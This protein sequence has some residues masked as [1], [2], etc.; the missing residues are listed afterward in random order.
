MSKILCLH[1]TDLDGACA[2]AICGYWCEKMGYDIDY[3]LYNYGYP[4]KESDFDGYDEI[5][6]VD[7][8]FHESSPWVYTYLGPRLTWIDHHKSA[9]E[10]E[11]KNY[12]IFKDLGIAGIREIG[13]GACELTWEYL[14]PDSRTPKLVQYLSTYDTWRKDREGFDWRTCECIQWGCRQEYGISAKDICNYLKLAELGLTDYLEELRS[15]GES[16][17]SYVEKNFTGKLKNYGSFI[18]EFNVEGI[19]SYR[20]MAL[21]T[22]EFTSKVFEGL[23]DPRYYDIM[24]PYCICPREGDPG[25]FDVRVSL[26]TEKPGID[27]SKIAE[28]FGGGGHIGAAGF[29]TTLETLSTILSCAMSL[30]EYDNW[31]YITGRKKC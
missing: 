15:K 5:F 14:F 13:K 24:M 3:R 7:I 31:L 4:L 27:V 20:V 9:I 23:F 21:N 25:K 26:Y 8:S 6:A 29:S 11:K 16:I 1:H 17:L 22:N 18:P 30:K 12:N 19:G 28:I 2:G 10:F